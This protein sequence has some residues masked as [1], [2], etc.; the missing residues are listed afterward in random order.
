MTN[1]W[2]WPA[3]V[4]LRALTGNIIDSWCLMNT[5]QSCLIL[6]GSGW[7]AVNIPQ[8]W[9]RH[10]MSNHFSS[11]CMGYPINA[12]RWWCGFSRIWSWL[13]WGTT[14]AHRQL[15]GY[16]ISRPFR[17]GNISNIWTP[18]G[19][20]VIIKLSWSPHHWSPIRTV[21]KPWE[22]RMLDTHDILNDVKSSNY[23]WSWGLSS[24]ARCIR[25]AYQPLVLNQGLSMY[26]IICY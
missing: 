18:Y 4:D 9:W 5:G 11:L 25:L 1:G 8:K 13:W 19:S 10:N 22:S 20:I 12:V 23:A 2:W 17:H 16:W 24:Y 6:L 26:N 3:M 14:M 21:V 15:F 7:C